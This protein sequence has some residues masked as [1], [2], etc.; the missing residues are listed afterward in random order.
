[1][2][3]IAALVLLFLT[4]IS[5]PALGEEACRKETYLDTDYVVCTFDPAKSDMRIYNRSNEGQPYG[6]FVSLAG[7]I[8]RTGKHFLRFAV[9]GGMY[10][11]DLSPVGLFVENGIEKVSVKTGWGWGNFYLRPNGVFYIDDKSA[12]VMETKA[13]LQSGL[14]PRYATQSGPMLVIDG[15]IH[16][17]F[18]PHSD[19]FKIRNGVGIDAVGKVNFVNSE[20][21]VR[22]YD[23]ALFY[24]DVL[25]SKNALFLDG[26]ISSLA[27]PDWGRFDN[28]DPMGP[29]IAVIG[30]LP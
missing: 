29:I 18:L 28:H 16:P 19:S 1:M 23:F 24:R 13:Y 30:T 8:W 3:Q 9:N 17:A 11:Y 2:V 26:S 22:F 5:S 6:S 27:I 12:D 4:A 25:N 21:P 10:H 15:K 7:D 20:E 14:K